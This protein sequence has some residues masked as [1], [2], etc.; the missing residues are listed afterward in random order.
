M[1]GVLVLRSL[2]QLGYSN[3]SDDSTTSDE[4]KLLKVYAYGTPSCFDNELAD[5]V[6]S[7]VTSVVLH[8]DVFP[9]LTPTSCRGL[10]KHLLYI[11][12]TWVKDH[13]EEDLRA[14]GERARTVWAPRFRQSFALRSSTSS[15]KK[16]CKKHIR[17]GENKLK[18][19]KKSFVK[20]LSGEELDNTI[21]EIRDSLSMDEYCD[22]T[23]TESVTTN[24]NEWGDKFI[25]AKTSLIITNSE[26]E[27]ERFGKDAN[28]HA[29][30]HSQAQSLLEFLGG[31]DNKRGGFIIDGDEFFET[32]QSVVEESHGVSESLCSDLFSDPVS[33]L[34]DDASLQVGDSWSLDMLKGESSPRNN[35]SSIGI[36]DE[37]DPAAVVLDESPLPRM[38]LPG[39]VIH[40]YSHRGVYKAAYVPRTFM[41]LRKI[42]LAG[43]MLSNHTTKS[44]FEGLLEVQT[45]R[46]ANESPPVWTA[47]DE[48]DTCSCCVNRFTWAS[49]SS[50]QAQEARDKH[51]C[52]SCGGLVCHPCSKNRVAIPSIGLN[53]PVRVCDRCY[54]GI[55]GGVSATSTSQRIAALPTDRF[56]RPLYNDSM[57]AAHQEKIKPERRRE[58]R[59]VVV[60]DL[61]SRMH[62]SALA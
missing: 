39:K 31:G 43:N 21:L 40:I 7:F 4:S 17:R 56:E 57:T 29:P 52:R 45:V 44:Y 61:V 30:D 23:E 36:D 24:P 25:D 55:M 32:G 60:D 48:D 2:E 34:V 53:V 50:S 5:S 26:D 27:G 46:V 41:E 13:I 37:N 18:S 47:F 9:R 54:N 58:K 49:T 6:T 38:Y 19:A 11:R 42:S 20:K 10:L 59:S 33:E 16:Y 35:Q 62:S 22:C 14:V 51:N 8:D 12:E 28:T 1:I 15:I 3:Q